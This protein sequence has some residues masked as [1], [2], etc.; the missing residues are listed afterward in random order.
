MKEKN[1]NTVQNQ[2]TAYLVMAVKNKR[3]SYLERRYRLREREY[4]CEEITDSCIYSF[5]SRFYEY[6]NRRVAEK[7]ENPIVIL[8]ILK[9][10]ESGRIIKAVGKLKEEEQGLLFGR[11]FGGQSFKEL[12]RMFGVSPKQAEMAY[13]YII[14]KVRK[15]SL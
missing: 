11:V 5:E 4:T 7:H 15:E 12:G 2:F 9:M 14:R 10:A 13:Y 8:E 1:E 3:I 6:M